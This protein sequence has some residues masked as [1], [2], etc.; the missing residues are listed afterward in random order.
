MK[1]ECV[2]ESPHV[3]FDEL[4]DETENHSCRDG[5]DAEILEMKIEHGNQETKT[6]LEGQIARLRTQGEVINTRGNSPTN[7]RVLR[8]HPL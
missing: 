8:N 5:D 7:I 3:N 4:N 1:N 2:E 6:R